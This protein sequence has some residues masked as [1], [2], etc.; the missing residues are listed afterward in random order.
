[1][2][3]ANPCPYLTHTSSLSHAPLRGNSFIYTYIILYM[4]VAMIRTQI[5]ITMEQRESL[6]KKAYENDSSL[7]DEI[8]KAI[9]A[10]LREEREN[11]FKNKL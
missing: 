3:G 5:Y 7:S 6:R 1:M 10:Y 8:R 4:E 11:D 2:Q 9:D